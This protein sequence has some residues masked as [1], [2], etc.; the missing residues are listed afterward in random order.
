MITRIIQKEIHFQLRTTY[1]G[2]SYINH[3]I[4]PKLQNSTKHCVMQRFVLAQQVKTINTQRSNSNWHT[5][6][7]PDKC[8][9]FILFQIYYQCINKYFVFNK[10]SNINATETSIILFKYMYLANDLIF[11]F[12]N[13][14]TDKSGLLVSK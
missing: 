8:Y 13:L 10:F 2:C 9:V 11:H 3:S 4:Y 1:S 14:L 12:K 5:D 7:V 6:Q